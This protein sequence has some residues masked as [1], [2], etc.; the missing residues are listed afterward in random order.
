MGGGGY[1]GLLQDQQGT[2]QGWA[3]PGEG[4]VLRARPSP[5][6]LGTPPLF[7]T[8]PPPPQSASVVPAPG[9]GGLRERQQPLGLRGRY[10]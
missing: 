5:W 9:A 4:N 8:P 7:L 1:D 6:R 10:F 2:R 3:T